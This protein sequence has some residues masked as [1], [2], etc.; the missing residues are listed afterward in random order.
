MAEED[1]DDPSTRFVLPDDAP[2]ATNLAALWAIDPKLAAAIDALDS[3]PSYQLTPSRS[4]PPTLKMAAHDGSHILLHSQYDPIEEARH[5]VDPMPIQDR[6]AFY[7]HGFGLGFHVQEL[8]DQVGEDAIL[9]VIEPDLITL[10]TAFE[11][12]DFST[13]IL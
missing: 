7:V 9:C 1:H 2:L 12:R 3:L 5:I 8:F 6:A 13:L 4:G 11:Q 10:R